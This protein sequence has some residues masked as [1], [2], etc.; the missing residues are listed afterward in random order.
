MSE[1]EIL[2]LVKPSM[3][4]SRQIEDFRIASLAADKG[5]S[6]TGGLNNLSVPAWLA[7]L[8]RKTMPETCPEGLVCDSV[9]LCVRECDKALVG[10]I[11]IRHRLNGYLLNYGGHVGY[12]IHPLHRCKGYAKEQLR[13]GLLQCGE[14]GINPVM[15]ACEPWNAASRAVILSQ[16]G[17][18]EDARV[19]PDGKTLERYWIH[20]DSAK[21]AALPPERTGYGT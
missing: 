11:N 14:L 20:L 3:D 1:R 16:G 8:E 13:L 15:L 12:S 5:M 2:A 7:L 10:M 19:N 21:S 18:F 9:F 17:Q 4:F 6:G